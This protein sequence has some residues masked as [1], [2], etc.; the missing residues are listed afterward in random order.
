MGKSFYIT[1]PDEYIE[2]YSITDDSYENTI[3]IFTN[4]RVITI[5]DAEKVEELDLERLSYFIKTKSIIKHVWT[6]DTCGKD[7]R[8]SFS[9]DRSDDRWNLNFDGGIT[10]VGVS[11]SIQ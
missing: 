7:F 9:D 2:S 11:L 8:L 1:Y 5:E 10:S 6:Y 3:T 4:Y